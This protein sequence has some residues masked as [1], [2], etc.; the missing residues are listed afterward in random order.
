MLIRV[1]IVR[2]LEIRRHSLTKKGVG[3]G[4][5]SDLSTKG[6]MLARLVGQELGPVAYVATSRTPRAIETAVAMGLAVDDTLD[7][8]AGYVPG[9]IEHH[10]QWTW[11]FPYRTYAEMIQRGAGIAAVAEVHRA[12]WAHIA[13]DLGEGQVALIVSHG[14]AIEPGLVSCLPHADHASWGAPFAHCDGAR[15]AVESGQFVHI[16]FRRAPTLNS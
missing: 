6:V 9:E 3:R 5:G 14:G 8:P 2:W 7:L 12:A 1:P 13:A 11:P 4:R 10:D 15:L 16:G